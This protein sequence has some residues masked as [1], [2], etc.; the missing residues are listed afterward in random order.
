MTNR[1]SQAE[2]EDVLS[3]IRRLV[4]EERVLPTA[5]ETPAVAP[6]SVAEPERLVLT[7][8]LRVPDPVEPAPDL[9]KP[10]PEADMAEDTSSAQQAFGVSYSQLAKAQIVTL[11][12]NDRVVEEPV[13]EELTDQITPDEA[14]IDA[15]QPEMDARETATVDDTAAA[16]TDQ[17]AVAG[18]AAHTATLSAK[19]AALEAVIGRRREQW[20]PDRTGEDAYAGTD[21]ARMIWEGDA[22]AAEGKLQPPAEETALADP[23]GPDR[24]PLP[25]TATIAVPVPDGASPEEQPSLAGIANDAEMAE[26]D[27]APLAVEHTAEPMPDR[28][29]EEVPALTPQFV[30]R[31]HDDAANSLPAERP[32]DRLLDEEDRLLDEEVLRDLVTDIIR[33]ELQGVLGERITRNVRKLVRRQIQR[34]LA[35]QG[36]D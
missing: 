14:P 25:D 15:P 21:G 10:E 9:A 11:H 8:A 27:T 17:A 35:A 24:E 22:Q 18:A 6:A 7:E 4:S 32:E 34:A 28:P 3:S 12:T 33:E 5:E 31:G 23:V 30:H 20:E 13:A 19:I 2:I 1:V 26:A 16:E 29:V 36:L